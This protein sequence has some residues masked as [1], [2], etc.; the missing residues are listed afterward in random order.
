MKDERWKMK[1]S[2]YLSHSEFKTKTIIQL[3]WNEWRVWGKRRTLCVII[4]ELQQKRRKH[5][6]RCLLNK[7]LLRC[8]T[9]LPLLH[10]LVHIHQ[11]SWSTLELNRKKRRWSKYWELKIHC[12]V[13]TKPCPLNAANV[14]VFQ[15]TGIKPVPH[16]DYFSRVSQSNSQFVPLSLWLSMPK[17]ESI[18]L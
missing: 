1:E 18:H 4:L 17:M 16:A 6:G 2:P 5:H 10:K 7:H 15:R 8:D 13:L 3:T 9:I 14:V 11:W 12:Y